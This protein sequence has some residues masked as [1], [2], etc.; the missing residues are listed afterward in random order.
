M[1]RVTEALNQILN[2][3]QNKDILEVACGCGE[4]WL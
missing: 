3:L 4:F 1:K 2:S